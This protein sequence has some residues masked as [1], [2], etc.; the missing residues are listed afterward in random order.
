MCA[1]KHKYVCMRVYICVYIYAHAKSA[2]E[3]MFYVLLKEEVLRGDR[4]KIFPWCLAIS[5]SITAGVCPKWQL[6]V[7]LFVST[8]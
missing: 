7:L 1:L 2:K 6:Y 5:I 4:D 8:E 3:V